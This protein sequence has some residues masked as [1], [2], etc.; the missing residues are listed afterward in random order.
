MS[1]GVPV[2][3]PQHHHGFGRQGDFRRVRL[4]KYRLELDCFPCRQNCWGDCDGTSASGA[5]T[6][7]SPHN[8]Y[9]ERV[10]VNE[11]VPVVHRQPSRNAPNK[12]HLR[13]L[14]RS[15]LA[16]RQCR[17]NWFGRRRHRRETRC[18]HSRA[19]HVRRQHTNVAN[20][21]LEV[22]HLRFER[23]VGPLT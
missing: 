17:R 21:I 8:Y 13:S 4:I 12:A 16:F 9:R 18:R 2:A 10:N 23:V 20:P 19:H 11:D 7:R 3:R 5:S 14:D 15:E 1:K 22:T 6:H